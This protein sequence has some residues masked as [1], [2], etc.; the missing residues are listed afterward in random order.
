M[1]GMG[2]YLVRE[3]IWQSNPLR[4]MKGPKVTPYSRLPRRIEREHMQA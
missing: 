4:W 3:G 1:R 2:D